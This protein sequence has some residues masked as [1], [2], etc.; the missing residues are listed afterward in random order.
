MLKRFTFLFLLFLVFFPGMGS[1]QRNTN[2]G[3]FV[4][5]AYYMGDINPNRHFYRPSL[6][7]GGLVRHNFNSRYALRLSG[8]YT[9]LSGSDLDFPGRLNPDRP[10]IPA[11]FQTSVLDIA[12]QVEFNFLPFTPN[13]GKWDYT[14]YISLGVAEGLIMGS[15]VDATNITSIPFGAGI[16][17]N[18]TS[19]I[20]AGAEWSFR[21]TFNDNM[22][23]VTNPSRTSSLLHN[24]DWYSFLGVFITFKFFNF[25]T[26][27][28]AYN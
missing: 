28:P 23:G 10:T 16:K 6:S 3:V 21:K 4:G 14:P 17:V 5:T 8:Y 11:G 24:N 1:A 19:R 20:S 18:L 7:L 13:I 2:I 9:H 22:D 15:S 25:A 27:C 26:E 12:L